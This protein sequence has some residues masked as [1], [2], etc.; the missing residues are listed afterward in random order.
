MHMNQ[1]CSQCDSEAVAALLQE[2]LC[3]K[4]AEE[5]LSGLEAEM[6]NLKENV[7]ELKEKYNQLCEKYDVQS[8]GEIEHQL[9][10]EGRDDITE[11]DV[12]KVNEA[13]AAY[14]GERHELQG[15]EKKI[16]NLKRSM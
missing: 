2:P 11:A 8:Y 9:N 14:T 6:A 13:E 16:E 7:E 3:Q 5:R 1:T 15:L 12:Q 10:V 4:H